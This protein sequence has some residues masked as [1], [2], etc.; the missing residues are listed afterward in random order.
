VVYFTRNLKR[1]VKRAL[2]L[3]HIVVK[4]EEQDFGLV[5][6]R[7]GVVGFIAVDCC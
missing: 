7:V 4:K 2:A 1:I 3:K 5:I 6:L